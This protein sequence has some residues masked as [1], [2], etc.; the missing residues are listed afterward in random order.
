MQTR[1]PDIIINRQTGEA[2]YYSRLS[3]DARVNFLAPRFLEFAIK[4]QNREIAD[5]K[6]GA[7]AVAK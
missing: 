3:I 7:P 6:T 1:H 5:N 2:T 4:E